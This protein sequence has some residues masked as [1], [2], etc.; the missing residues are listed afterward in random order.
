LKVRSP[1]SFGIRV[2]K[3]E[4]V[5]P[6]ILIQFCDFLTIFSKSCFMV[7]Q[8]DLK[9]LAM[10]PSGPGALSASIQFKAFLISCRL[11]GVVKLIFSPS[12]TSLGTRSRGWE[13]VSIGRSSEVEYKS[14]KKE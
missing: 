14:L 6:P 8:Q 9:N 3:D 13:L 4:L 11:I 5:L 10:K 1:F 7:G 12:W 2:K